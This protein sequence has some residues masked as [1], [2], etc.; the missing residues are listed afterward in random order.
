MWSLT[1]AVRALQ[2]LVGAALG[3][4]TVHFATRPIAGGDI[5]WMVRTGRMILDTA[6]IPSTDTFSYTV[7][8]A[9]WNNHEWLYEL[10]AALLHR[11][12]GWTSLRLMVLAL[13]GGSLVAYG[14]RVAR[15]TSASLGLA[16]AAVALP[17]ASF[18][19]MPAPQTASMA[20]LCVAWGLF[21]RREAL[22]T[23]ARVTALFG[24]MVV[25]GNLTA[26]AF[27]FVPF[28]FATHVLY[29]LE[30]A[31]R[32]RQRVA[33][34]LL[35][36][37]VAP[38]L[39]PPAS[40]TLEYLLVGS[41]VNRAVNAEFAPLWAP[42]ATVPSAIKRVA[43]AVVLA[44]GAVTAARLR[45]DASWPTRRRALL[46]A[47]AC[48]GAVAYERNLFLVAVPL[49]QL[50][51]DAHRAAAAR[52]RTVAL[53]VAA[54]LAGALVFAVFCAQI[55]WTPAALGALSTARYWRD[56]LDARSLPVAC[57]PSIR[58]LPRGA[59]VFTSRQWASL[60]IFEAPQAR[61][62]IDGRN[63]E[64][65]VELH[66]I[67]GLMWRAAPLTLRALDVS[68]TTHVLAPPAWAAQPATRGGP[69]R[70]TFLSEGCALFERAP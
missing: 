29:A 19:L 26:E 7:F 15:A 14:R 37:A 17:L 70:A 16:A 11:A 36:A 63:R 8:G 38:M 56:S 40:S 30:D 50:L 46:G 60:V 1:P 18:K 12:G 4:A 64:Y 22:S 35:L 25:W 59:R 27:T 43:L 52:A 55:G 2:I 41:A 44:W 10:L 6:S 68:Q 53:D 23:G 62:F 67:A 3:L 61:V 57:V 39:T 65:P 58:A 34:A 51:A 13:F 24:F 54:T 45:G 20:M 69:W 33:L 48:A 32:R 21:L 31:T 42:A 9:R 49:A 5:F 47:L 28:L 66:Q